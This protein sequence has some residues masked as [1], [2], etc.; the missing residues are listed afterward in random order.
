MSKV[1]HK[2]IYQKYKSRQNT[3][4]LQKRQAIVTFSDSDS[5]NELPIP[6]LNQPEIE[7]Y[8]DEEHEVNMIVEQKKNK[9]RRPMPNRNKAKQF[10]PRP[11]TGVRKLRPMPPSVKNTVKRPFP[12]RFRPIPAQSLQETASA[13]TDENQQQNEIDH[14]NEEKGEEENVLNNDVFEEEE[15]EEEEADC[16]VAICYF[17]EKKIVSKFN[18]SK[19]SL[20]F[21]KGSTSILSNVFEPKKDCYDVEINNQK[22]C[23]L[24]D[25]NYC[26][27]SLKKNSKT[28]ETIFTMSYS[29]SKES[30]KSK[31]CTLNFFQEIPNAPNVVHNVPPT[32]NANGDVVNFFGHRQVIPSSNNMLFLDKDGYE[33]LAVMRISKTSICLEVSPD[34]PEEI[35]YVIG[36]SAFLNQK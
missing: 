6:Y 17:I 23:I 32:L 20:N 3:K 29:S 25:D 28:G 12:R 2:K 26:S 24:I 22:Y 18:N 19:M 9:F 35:V 27:F 31:I 30:N 1:N 13:T 15:D 34:I 36:I 21:T 7:F 10:K 5:D 33:L 4:N 8:S 11:P 14:I 16:R